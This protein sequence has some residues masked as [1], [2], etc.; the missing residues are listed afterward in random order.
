MSFLCNLVCRYVTIHHLIWWH[1]T[2]DVSHLCEWLLF[3]LLFCILG[4]G[5]L[6][7]G[8]DD[9]VRYNHSFTLSL[10]VLYRKEVFFTSVFHPLHYSF[11][12][13]NQEHTEVDFILD[14]SHYKYSYPIILFLC[15]CTNL[16]VRRNF[17][18][19]FRLIK[20]EPGAFQLWN[21]T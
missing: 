8:M 18:P 10:L 5:C 6:F 2:F 20:F 3:P 11:F 1:L 19:S 9:L 4:N 16:P 7:D 12:F 14:L 17:N 15:I 13:R 21:V